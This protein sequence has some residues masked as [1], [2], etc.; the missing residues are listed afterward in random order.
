MD[1]CPMIQQTILPHPSPNIDSLFR[2]LIISKSGFDR[3]THVQ[4]GP[5]T[6]RVLIF[7]I[8][9]P[10]LGH[11]CNFHGHRCGKWRSTIFLG[12]S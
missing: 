8:S 7:L 1:R 3:P 12:T 10:F 2:D 6:L 9:C 4:H 5:F 11:G